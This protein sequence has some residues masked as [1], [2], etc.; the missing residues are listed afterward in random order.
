MLLTQF[1]QSFQNKKQL[2]LVSFA[3]SFIFF[4][5]NAVQQFIAG[6]FELDGNK[7]IAFISLA[8]IYCVFILSMFL[9]PLIIQ[10]IGTRKSM[11]YS[12][13]LYA[14]YPLA[15]ASKNILFL[16]SASFLVGLGAG[17]LW[18]GL[19]VHIISISKK[20]EYGRN[21][22]IFYFFV[23]FGTVLGVLLTSILIERTSLFI[24]MLV[25]TIMILVSSCFLF[26]TK[27]VTL[28]KNIVENN[29][30]LFFRE[31]KLLLVIA[32]A[33]PIGTIYT[34]LYGTFAVL[35]TQRFGLT[36]VGYVAII[37]YITPMIIPY[38]SGRIS[39]KYSKE[40]ILLIALLV[41]LSA[42]SLLYFSLFASQTFLFGAMIGIFLLFIY[43]NT[44]KTV[45]TSLLADYF[46][47]KGISNALSCLEASL[48]IVTTTF[49]LLNTVIS[50]TI[51]MYIVIGMIVLSVVPL[52]ILQKD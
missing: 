29:L 21:L 17:T 3:F 46:H 4:G 45:T 22:G 40:K 28:P 27:E 47:Q 38:L 48:L 31:R 42:I 36:A 37:G 9:A 8:I 44:F 25:H 41:G 1:K 24:I 11:L 13:L 35:I 43:Y 52:I 14:S 49:L 18:N 20:E 10:K 15:V 39:D 7:N 34:L 12:A 30:L 26:M 32:A 16:Y 51:I 50:P 2:Y 33:L 6:I 5:Y 19:K 23:S